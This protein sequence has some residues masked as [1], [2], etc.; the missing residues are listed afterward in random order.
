VTRSEKIFQHSLF[1]LPP[2]ISLSLFLSSLLSLYLL[3]KKTIRPI[4]L[5]TQEAEIK[6]VV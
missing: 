4:I 3:N 6:K 2:P 1:P 5:A